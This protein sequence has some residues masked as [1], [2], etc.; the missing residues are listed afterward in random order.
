MSA[1][2]LAWLMVASKR[3]RK[4]N[5]KSDAINYK[6]ASCKH[7][8]SIGSLDFS[9]ISTG[10]FK[11][12]DPA[13]KQFFRRPLKILKP[14]TVRIKE[15]DTPAHSLPTMAG[16]GI[17]YSFD[18]DKTWYYAVNKKAAYYWSNDPHS[19]KCLWTMKIVGS[20][21]YLHTTQTGINPFRYPTDQLALMHIS[22]QKN[23]FIL[24]SA[25]GKVFGKGIAFVGASGAG[26][27][28]IS[29]LL[30]KIKETELL[31]DDRLFI[32]RIKAT[33]SISGTPWPGEAGIAVN[34]SA[35]LEALFLLKQ[36]K[37][38]RIEEISSGRAFET[39]ASTTSIPW[40]D[41]AKAESVMA[42]IEL[43]LKSVPVYRFT[44]TPDAGAI[45]AIR[46]F[47]R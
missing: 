24:H 43:M 29:R 46:S 12:P 14:I 20:K 7:L 35:P 10:R 33:W 2:H 16:E 1:A 27:T 5:L 25:G 42:S 39:L 23:G 28:T 11:E 40:N 36:G 9:I 26:K 13:Y 45:K 3:A 15:S 32:Q 44:F 47:C 37:D 19:G 4:R 8:V 18:A 34:K 41:K 30:N 31:S 38:N 21:L 22:S 17:K 6:R